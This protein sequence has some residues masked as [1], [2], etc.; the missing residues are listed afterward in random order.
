MVAQREAALSGE[1]VSTW[2]PVLRWSA[3]VL[4]VLAL[5]IVPWLIWG[6]AVEA[7]IELMLAS[8]EAPPYFLWWVIGL[9]ALD[10]FLPI[11]SSLVAVAAGVFLGVGLGWLATFSGLMLGSA[12]GYACGWLWGPATARK[13]VGERDWTR[14]ERWAQQFGALLVLVLRPVPVLAEASTFYAGA[15]RVPIG[16]F[17]AA[18]AIGNAALAG[19]Y[20]SVGSLSADS[21]ELEPALMAGFLMPGLALLVVRSV[22]RKNR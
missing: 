11:P 13:V 19:V 18:N 7:R 10:V 9:L 4:G 3:L 6:T 15:S 8:H 21:G 22:S 20:A 5:V 17:V 14:A 12:W 2:S 16:W 1:A